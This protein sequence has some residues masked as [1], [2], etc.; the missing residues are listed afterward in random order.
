M[1]QAQKM[2][3]EFHKK[4]SHYTQNIPAFPPKEIREFRI[5]LIKEEVNELVDG[6][7]AY[8][9]GI[10]EIE[11]LTEVADAL[12]DILYVVYGTALAFG[13][14]IEPIFEEIHR[15]NMLK[16]FNKSKAGKSIKGPEWQEPQL[17]S[18]IESQQNQ[19]EISMLDKVQQALNTY[20]V[21]IY[22]TDAT[23]RTEEKDGN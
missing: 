3:L 1:N 5:D 7:Y 19:R 17:E 12:G 22:R 6:I 8:Q 11:C 16:S 18:I 23:N 21:N 15:T 2:V 13:L 4:F 14:D 9:H 10:S 20:Q